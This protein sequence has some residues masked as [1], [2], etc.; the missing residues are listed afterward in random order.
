MLRG[1]RSTKVFKLQSKFSKAFG[2]LRGVRNS[3][4]IKVK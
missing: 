4:V 1:V 3:Q 2:T